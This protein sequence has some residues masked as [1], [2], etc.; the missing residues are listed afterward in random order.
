MLRVDLI[1]GPNR[2][3]PDGTV[4]VGQAQQGPYHFGAW[5]TVVPLAGWSERMIDPQVLGRGLLVL[6]IP[7][8]VGGPKWT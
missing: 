2:P 4:T 1:T 7:C 8:V 6:G 5:V 3:G